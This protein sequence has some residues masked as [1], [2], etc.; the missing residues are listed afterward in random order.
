MGTILENFRAITWQ[1][2]LM[3]CIGG[4]LNYLAIRNNKQP[5]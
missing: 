2:L 4:G 1:M 3:W 5:A